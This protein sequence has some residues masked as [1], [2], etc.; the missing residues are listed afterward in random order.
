MIAKLSLDAGE[1]ALLAEARRATL[2]TVAPDG[3]PRLVPICYAVHPTLAILHVAIDDKPK[4]SSDPRRLARV[5]D[6]V[7]DPRVSVLVDRWDETWSRLAWL[8]CEG[9]ASLLEPGGDDAAERAAAIAA[10]RQRYPPYAGHDL[11]AAL[12][13][14]IEI[15]RTRSWGDL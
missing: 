9:R 15:L 12:L 13:L 8:R 14:R 11:E 4:R 6:I 1:R 2:A 7:R 5:R 10:L 3:M